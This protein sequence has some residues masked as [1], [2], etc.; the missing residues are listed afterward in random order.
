MPTPTALYSILTSSPTP[1]TSTIFPRLRHGRTISSFRVTFA[2]PSWWEAFSVRTWR[3]SFTLRPKLTWTAALLTPA[4]SWKPMWWAPTPC[5]KR[6]DGR[7]SGA[8]CTSRPTRSMGVSRRAAKRTSR[9][10]SSRAAPTRPA[11]RHRTSWCGVFAGPMAFPLSSLAAL[12][13]TG[14]TSFRRSSSPS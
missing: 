2:T 7:V 8:S 12:T 10:L 14:R 1:Q 3:R 13:I 4:P 9:R 6:L 11:R 5:S